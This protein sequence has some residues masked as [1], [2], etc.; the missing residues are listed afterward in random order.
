MSQ[1]KGEGMFLSQAEREGSVKG[2]EGRANKCEKDSGRSWRWAV[3][4]PVTQDFALE[5]EGDTQELPVVL[6][7]V[8]KE[9]VN[10]R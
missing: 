4:S 10:S 2:L 6:R 9:Q 3:L 8:T 7:Q 5:T 1:K